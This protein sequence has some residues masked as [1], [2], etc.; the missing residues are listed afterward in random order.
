MG[1]DSAR[2]AIR[3]RALSAPARL[4]ASRGAVVGR[5]LDFG[6]GHG[7]DAAALGV[8][9]WDPFHRPTPQPSGEYRT[10][11]CTYVLNT[12]TKTEAAAVV[13]RVRALLAPGG[14]AYFTVRRDVGTD[15]RTRSGSYQRNVRL[16]LPVFY[17]CAGGFCIYILKRENTNA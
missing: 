2:T 8:D 4:L 3:R 10:I 16:T 5:T 11:L 12:L 14:C 1:A 7:F 9:G 17:Q 15:G 13:D 6:C